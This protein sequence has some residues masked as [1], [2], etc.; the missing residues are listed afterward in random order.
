[1]IVYNPSTG[2]ALTTPYGYK[3]RHCFLMTQL[4]SPIPD[5]ADAMRARVTALL[6]IKAFTAIDANAEVTGRDLLVKIWNFL[7][8]TPV[9]IALCHK[10]MPEKT[11]MNVIY[12]LGV[13]QAM[14]NET[15]L[16][17]TPEFTV[18]SDLIGTEYV[19]F[20]GEFDR[21][22]K[23][24]LDNLLKR[25]KHYEE[26]GD[27]VGENNPVLSLDYYRRAYLLSGSNHLKKKINDKIKDAGL[28][29]R[30]K[31]SVEQLV[32]VF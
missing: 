6:K 19:K 17:K 18:P 26:S 29:E 31:N 32:A 8:A 2:E 27:L 14:G 23:K 7:T 4:G 10:G 28:S 5:I 12:E 15:L 11:L 3:P 20:D 30:A 22:F 25:A 13:A 1:M 24:Y 9:A 16:V 21:Q